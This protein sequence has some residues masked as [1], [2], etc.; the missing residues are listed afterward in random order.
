MRI[1]RCW[2]SPSRS[3]VIHASASVNGDAK[4]TVAVSPT[5]VARPVGDDVHLELA[6]VVPRHPVRA[7]C[8]A[9][10][11][12][13]SHRGCFASTARSVTVYVPP[14]GGVKVHGAGSSPVVTVA[15]RDRV[16]HPLADGL[17]DAVALAMHL[18]PFASRDDAVHAYAAHATAS[19]AAP[20]R[21]RSTAAC[22]PSRSSSCRAPW[23]RCRTR[24]DARS[25][26]CAHRP[27]GDSHPCTFAAIDT[28][29]ARPFFGCGSS[30]R[31][32]ARAR[33]VERVCAAREDLHVLACCSPH[34]P[35]TSRCRR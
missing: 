16:R 8:P 30:T 22:P 7:G 2:I 31:E 17:R 14:A 23:R 28:R 4:S 26:T 34:P 32:R 19:R 1:R 21:C 35:T 27:S 13:S 5:D 29:T 25:S 12:S 6:L 20:R 24:P 3:T 33:R 9:I 11:A 18:V 10:E 15:A